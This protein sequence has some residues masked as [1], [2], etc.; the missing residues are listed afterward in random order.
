MAKRC[1]HNPHDHKSQIDA[2]FIQF[3]EAVV[4]RCSAKKVFLEIS[5]NS[6]ENTCAKVSFLTKLQAGTQLC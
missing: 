2:L 5:Q 1:K 6:Q 4:Q 3:K